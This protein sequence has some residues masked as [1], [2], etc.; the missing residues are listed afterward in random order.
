MTEAWADKNY[1]YYLAYIYGRGYKTISHE[2]KENPMHA[3]LTEQQ[4]RKLL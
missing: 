3:K 2:H 1:K 4:Q